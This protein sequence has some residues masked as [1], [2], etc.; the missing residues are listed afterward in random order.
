MSRPDA[1]VAL[2]YHR[3]G[4]PAHDPFGIAVT[5]EHFAEHVEV[6]A[7]HRPLALSALAAEIAAG[8]LAPGG[9][10]V[11]FDDGYHDNLMAAKPVLE[12]A[13]VPATVFVTTGLTGTR[14]RF[15]WEELDDLVLT[16]ARP[17]PAVTLNAGDGARTFR[18]DG[19]A[20]PGGGGL[21]IWAWL[22]ERPTAEIDPVLAELRAWR[23]RTGPLEAGEDLRVMSPSEL[24][25][26]RAGGLIDIG[27]HTRTHPVL[28]AQPLGVQ[29]A[30]IEGSR[31]DLEG[32][33]GEPVRGFAY[34]F[35]KRGPEYSRATAA[36]VRE[37]GFEW[38]C[39]IHPRNVTRRTPVHEIPRHVP[40]D[41]DGDAFDAWLR[42]R[43]APAG[44]VR[45]S[46][47]SLRRRLERR[48]TSTASAVTGDR[49]SSVVRAD[50]RYVL[51]G[52][53][54]RRALAP[55]AGGLAE[56]A[57]VVAGEVV[58]S[59]AAAQCDLAVLADPR[60][61]DLESAFAALE[62]GGVLYAEW[63]RPQLGGEAALRR[64]L[65]AAG[66]EDP[67]CI[68]AW[69]LP[70]R[71]APVYWLPLRSPAAVAHLFATRPQR[72]GVR[73]AL[74]ARARVLGW[75]LARSLGALPL[76]ATARRP[77]GPPPGG[78]GLGEAIAGALAIPGGAG[79]CELLVLTGGDSVLNKVVALPFTAAEPS[80]R[81]AVKL[82]RVARS[83]GTL[84]NE[85]QVLERLT[86]AA[87]AGIPRI[88]A[89]GRWGGSPLVAESLIEGQPLWRHIE[90]GKAVGPVLERAT[91]LLAT[92]ATATAER[93]TQ[94]FG[95]WRERVAHEARLSLTRHPTAGQVLEAAQALLGPL[96][97]VAAT[98][99]HG[100]CTPWNLVVAADGSVGLL[101]WESSIVNGLPLFDL[102]YLLGH[103]A[104][105]A[106]GVADTP[107]EPESYRRLLDPTT[108][109]GALRLRVE[110]RYAEATGLPA[111]ALRP[112]RIATWVFQHRPD[113][114]AVELGASGEGVSG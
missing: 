78:A 20:G 34:P 72:P 85:R 80:P 45:R 113:I 97:D 101:D 22:R 16:G 73:G 43:L 35:G 26:L 112:L 102:T 74:E 51:P 62:P 93:G 110:R 104:M 98:L 37:A 99:L 79:D 52:G 82:A 19:P 75:R 60:G 70:A 13:G 47:A 7:R 61:R 15:W 6:L 59:A 109:L 68:F 108:P 100:D 58:R 50:W 107:A 25:S 21:E 10:A 44:R 30:E 9:V 31:A 17:G 8:T 105:Y 69:P 40:P 95:G 24:I 57:G 41:V 94:P 103:T 96:D 42:E 91:D 11:T 84:E 29:R 90:A 46:A 27:A 67:R 114:V 76:S 14:G 92:V 32:W 54:G 36:L 81:A 88:L 38:A 56:S 111:H 2:C 1:T 39:A 63:R 66:F 23:G 71:R 83:I 106:D 18:F 33:L 3:V 77:G 4:R 64:R 48:G 49:S 53:P 5:P 87:I 89:T 12:R 86:P 65:H 55:A 28:A